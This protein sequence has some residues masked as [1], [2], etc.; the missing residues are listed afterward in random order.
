MNVSPPEL[1]IGRTCG[2]TCYL[3]VLWITYR[4]KIRLLGQV[5]RS[6]QYICRTSKCT[7]VLTDP[8]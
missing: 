8:F 4:G 2:Q 3:D 7:D 1:G 6:L 5:Q